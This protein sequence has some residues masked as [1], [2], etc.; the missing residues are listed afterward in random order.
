MQAITTVFVV[1]RI[2]GGWSV[3][4]GD[5]P[6]DGTWRC[7][8]APSEANLQGATQHGRGKRAPQRVL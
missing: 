7:Q 1:E 6:P 8:K 5:D 2:S 4:V 3:G